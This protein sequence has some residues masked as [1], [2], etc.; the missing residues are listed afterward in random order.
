[1]LFIVQILKKEEQVTK[2]KTRSK[3]KVLKKPLHKKSRHMEI[4]LHI[5]S[6]ALKKLILVDGYVIDHR[7][8]SKTRPTP[9]PRI[10]VNE[11]LDLV[12]EMYNPSKISRD[13]REIETEAERMFGKTAMQS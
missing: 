6:E 2:L 8:V 12:V 5:T 1:M 13:E 9:F 11:K 3:S 10:T 4:E 7:G